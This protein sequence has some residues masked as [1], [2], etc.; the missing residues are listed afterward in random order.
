MTTRLPLPD[1]LRALGV[2][3]VLTTLTA[4]MGFAHTSASAETIQ[5]GQTST[6]LAAPQCPPKV[7]L[8]NCKIVL[9]HTTAVE[10]ASDGVASPV[11]VTRPGWIVGFSV[12]VSHLVANPKTEVS[13]IHGED[14]EWGGT[15]RVQLTVLK[16]AGQD[17]YT[18]AAQSA[19]LHVIPFL[20]QVVS[21]PLS[22]PPS[23]AS[24]TALP[25]KRGDVIGLT[26][27]TWAPVITYDLTPAAHFT[28]RQSRRLNCLNPPASQTAQLTIG[29]SASYRCSYTGT[30]IE[31]SATE[32]TDTPYPKT[33]VH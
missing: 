33:Y 16:P 15:P 11:T 7:A 29:S 23:F 9:A 3:C 31:Y 19:P 6:P 4:L 25:V 5:L 10:T 27:P 24:L 8:A 28:Y 26:I 14:A 20:G 1:R 2:L 30:R 12:G 32:I 18:V 17:T 13:I 22:L 21:E